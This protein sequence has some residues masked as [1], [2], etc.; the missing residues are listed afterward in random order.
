MAPKDLQKH[1]GVFLSLS[2]L[3][4]L[5]FWAMIHVPGL[6]PDQSTPYQNQFYIIFAG[7][8]PDF[9]FSQIIARGAQQ[10]AED[11]GVEIELVWSRWDQQQMVID[12]KKALDRAPDGIALMGHP[13]EQ[14]LAPLVR[15][16]QRKGV[17][18]TT[19]NVDLPQLE[20]E[21]SHQGFGY[22]GQDIYGSG[23]TLAEAVLRVAQ[24][25][26]GET[27][28]VLGSLMFPIRG[29]RSQAILDTLMAQDLR[30]VYQEG[31]ALRTSQQSEQEQEEI[32]RVL[33]EQN[34]GARILIDD[35]NL[36]ATTKALENLGVPPEDLFLAGFDLSTELVPW[37]ETERINLVS[38]Q[39]PFL[40]G[41][42]SV[43]Q[44]VLSRT[45]GFSGLR[46]DTGTGIV[47]PDLLEQMRPHILQGLR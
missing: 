33:L 16:A 30:V 5:V 21:F 2:I 45:W 36:L 37:L 3:L 14:A 11:L 4:F 15:E 20:Q 47:T 18:I 24:P 41:Y 6:R 19:L 8:S 44:L 42:L 25:Q 46:I 38:D 23:R 12:V 40:Q 35:V 27:I 26:V 10:A 17:I 28:L 29:Q 34:P 31:P 32:I 43:V 22:V 9:P 13:G 39:Q 1:L 7:G